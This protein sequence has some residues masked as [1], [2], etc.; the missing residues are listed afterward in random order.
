MEVQIKPTGMRI[1]VQKDKV[2]E[3]TSGGIYKPIEQKEGMRTGTVLNVGPGKELSNGRMLTPTAKAGD[4]I[5]FSEYAGTKVKVKGVEHLL[6]DDGDILAF[7][8]GDM[9]IE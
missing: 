9:K 1:L 2:E 3:K 7:F 8:D 5:V 4:R 6:M